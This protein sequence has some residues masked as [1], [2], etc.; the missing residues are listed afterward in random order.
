MR[1]VCSYFQMQRGE[2]ARC[3]REGSGHGSGRH[4]SEIIVLANHMLAWG[5]KSH[6]LVGLRKFKILCCHLKKDLFAQREHNIMSHNFI[7]INFIWCRCHI[8]LF[9][10]INL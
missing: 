3:D 1:G 10:K 7:I 9:S 5:C 4:A 6:S 8:E 2:D